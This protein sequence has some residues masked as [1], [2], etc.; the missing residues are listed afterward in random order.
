MRKTDITTKL[1]KAF[2]ELRIEIKD[3]TYF[4]EFEYEH[5]FIILYI[6]NDDNEFTFVTNVIDTND[7]LNESNLESAFNAVEVFHK[8]FTAE[9]N[10][11]DPYFASP[12]YKIEKRGK[13]SSEWIKNQLKE[14]ISIYSLDNTLSV[15]GFNNK[16]DYVIYNS[17]A[18]TIIQMLEVDHC[19][20]FLSKDN[21]K[22]LEI[23]DN[24]LVL[25]G[26]SID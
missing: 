26:T 13:I 3:N 17:I 6:F 20:I 18:K 12:T 22:G 7:S 5:L 8:D 15:L 9:W 10:N 11:G 14:L 1:K 21:A 24:D 16:E 2:K 25:V 19:H 4:Y 23:G